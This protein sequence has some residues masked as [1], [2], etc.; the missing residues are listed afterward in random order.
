MVVTAPLPSAMTK[1]ITSV[2]TGLLR[3]TRPANRRSATRVEITFSQP[4]SR[5]CSRTVTVDP[6]SRRAARRASAGDRPSL[7][8]PL[9]RLLDVVR[10]LLIE[11]VVCLLAPGEDPDA[12][13]EL[14]PE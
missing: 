12:A 3:S 4:W 9:G 14:S 13:R 7:D 5:T 11:L 2:N 10:Q 1:T 8:V 6:T